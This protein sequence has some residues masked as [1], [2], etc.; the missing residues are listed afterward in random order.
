MPI[1]FV[2]ISSEFGYEYEVINLL[3]QIKNVKEVYHTYGDYDAIAKVEAESE[4]A[5]NETIAYHIRQIT[6]IQS[7]VTL[8]TVPG[9]DFVRE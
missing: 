1:A 4:M 3:K 2:L 9:Q 7:T 8:T 6:R 5:L